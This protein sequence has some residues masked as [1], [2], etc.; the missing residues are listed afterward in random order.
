MSISQ[1]INKTQLKYL[2]PSVATIGPLKGVQ[3][4]LINQGISAK[5]L[6]KGNLHHSCQVLTQATI[7]C[8]HAVIHQNIIVGFNNVSYIF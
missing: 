3:L 1:F 5:D 6:S 7:G 4:A 8:D 2:G